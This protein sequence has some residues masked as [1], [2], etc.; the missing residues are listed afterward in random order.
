MYQFIYFP[1]KPIEDFL[2]IRPLVFPVPNVGWS[3]LSNEDLRLSSIEEPK[4]RIKL[5]QNA[6][7]RLGVPLF[8]FQSPGPVSK[9]VLHLPSQKVKAIDRLGVSKASGKIRGKVSVFSGFLVSNTQEKDSVSIEVEESP[10]LVVF[11]EIFNGFK[12][13]C[14]AKPDKKEIS[15][16]K[17][18]AKDPFHGKQ[19]I[20]KTNAIFLEF[21]DHLCRIAD[22]IGVRS[23][24][25]RFRRSA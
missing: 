5:L 8:Y 24:A 12:Y 10:L 9:R 1:A 21:F 4:L 11:E 23:K 3:F 17:M 15:A 22:L 25:K 16:F 13:P 20:V 14:R 2:Q 18:S 7:V 19:S 6:V